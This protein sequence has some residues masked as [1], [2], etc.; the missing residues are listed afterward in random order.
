CIWRDTIERNQAEEELRQTLDSLRKAFGTIVQVLV[1]AVETRD[2]YT[3]GQQILS[4]LL[5]RR[6]DFLRI[7]SMASA[8]TVP[9]MTS[10]EC[11]SRQSYCPSQQNFLN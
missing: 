5:P 7:K 11:L 4:A 1:S 10:G 3:S 8:W 9:S 6:W 2:P